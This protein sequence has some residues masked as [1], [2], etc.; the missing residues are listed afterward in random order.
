MAHSSPQAQPDLQHISLYPLVL[1]NDQHHLKGTFYAGFQRI[2]SF[3]PQIN[4]FAR[5]AA[6]CGEVLVFAYPDT[7]VPEIPGI[8]FVLLE[9]SAPL[10]DE[11]FIVFA[12]SEFQMALLTRQIKE[13]SPTPSPVHQFGRERNY[14]GTV[15]TQPELVLAASKMLDEVLHRTTLEFATEQDMTRM[16]KVQHPIIT[17]G[18]T[19]T[20]YL[21]QRNRELAGLYRTLTARTKPWKACS[22]LCAP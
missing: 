14:Q 18:Q 5:L 6:I 2:S 9:E 1:D 16:M 10:A 15:T 4:R 11:W 7:A 13:D 21:E 12:T 8:Q 20:N 22:S 19:L 3:I 17:F